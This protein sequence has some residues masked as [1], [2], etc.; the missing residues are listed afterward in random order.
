MEIIDK[1]LDEVCNCIKSVPCRRAVRRELQN[2]MED[3]I[4]YA[5]EK[6]ADNE[7][8]TEYAIAEMGNA[9]ETGRQLNEHFSVRPDIRL[10]LYVF[11]ISCLYTAAGLRINPSF[12]EIVLTLSAYILGICLFHALKRWDLEGNSHLIKYLYAGILLLLSAVCIFAD[13]EVSR[14]CMSTGGTLLF[15]CITFF[16]YRLHKNG[17]PGLI[18][19][20]CLFLLPVPLFTL[21][22]AYAALFLYIAAGG[23]TFAC[24]ILRGWG[25]KGRG[26][27]IFTL[28]VFLILEVFVILCRTS[29]F[30]KCSL[31]DYFPLH[32]NLRHFYDPVEGFRTFPLTTCI[33]YYGSWTAL[34]YIVLFSLVLAELIRIKRKLHY[35][36]GRNMLNCIFLIFL[37]KGVFAVL[38]NLGIPLVR[39]YMLPFT[40][41]GPDQISNFLLIVMAEYVYCFGDAVFAD[42]SFF[43]EHKFAFS[44]K[45]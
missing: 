28:S 24:F 39:Y 26:K 27:M 21:T 9:K 35:F 34:L 14:E 13:S 37:I 41:F 25:L 32:G 1:Y 3:S 8:A 20:L 11:G 22:S 12:W 42:Y 18:A 30:I 43:E 15:F 44:S 19:A 45:L 6:G 7:E 2:H 16:I 4:E 31:W 17:M 40:G 33:N 10:V 38:L 36:W 29:L 5:K 23:C